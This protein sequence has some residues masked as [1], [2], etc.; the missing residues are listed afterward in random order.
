MRDRL[1]RRAAE[2]C[3]VG[4]CIVFLLAMEYDDFIKRKGRWCRL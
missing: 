3:V 2:A 1:K 4:A